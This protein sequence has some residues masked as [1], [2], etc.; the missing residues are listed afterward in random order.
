MSGALVVNIC[1]CSWSGKGPKCV[2]VKGFKR[3]ASNVIALYHADHSNLSII[4]ITRLL[5]LPVGGI[6]IRYTAQKLTLQR[7]ME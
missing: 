5:V 6:S 7:G 1:D 4:A 2:A 3:I